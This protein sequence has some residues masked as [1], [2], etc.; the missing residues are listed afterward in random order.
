MHRHTDTTLDDAQYANIHIGQF[1]DLRVEEVNDHNA[2]SSARLCC[3]RCLNN[4]DCTNLS[5]ISTSAFKKEGDGCFSQ[6]NR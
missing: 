1:N 4:A 3:L 5:S 2:E 6:E